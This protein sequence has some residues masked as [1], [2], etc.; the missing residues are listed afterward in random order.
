MGPA[1]RFS[2]PIYQRDKQLNKCQLGNLFFFQLGLKNKCACDKHIKWRRSNL[3]SL[4]LQRSLWTDFSRCLCS[5]FGSHLVRVSTKLP[6]LARCFGLCFCSAATAAA[7]SVPFVCECDL[8]FLHLSVKYR[9]VER[10]ILSSRGSPLA[11]FPSLETHF[12]HCE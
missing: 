8:L 12:I 4:L 3:H 1:P 5:E 11:V 9:R 6:S 2:S 10:P 7:A